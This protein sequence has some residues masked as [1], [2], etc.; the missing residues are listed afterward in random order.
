MSAAPNFDLL[1]QLHT[2]ARSRVLRA[3]GSDGAALI[4]KQPNQEFPSFQDNAR[5]RREFEIARRCAH[6]GV[7]V[8]LSLTQTN[9]HWT[10]V[11]ADIGGIALDKVLRRRALGTSEFFA[12]A[13]QLCD[14]VDAVHAQGVIHKDINPSNLVWNAD[15]G[16]LQLIDFGIASELSQE[17]QGIV[18][19][20]ALEGTLA[21][22]APE[23]TGRMNRL[24][25]YRADLYAI[26]ATL[27]TLLAGQPP[28][29][30][31]DAMELIHCHIARAPGWELPALQVLPHGLLAILQRLLEKDAG[32][33]YQSLRAL[34]ADLEACRDARAPQPARLADR[35]ARFV[36][37]HGLY[38]RDAELAM[39]MAA[40]ER[41]AAGGTE[42]LLVAGYSGIGK[43]ALV[44]EV[45][46]PIVAR[47]GAFLAGKFDQFRR[48]VPYA[49]LLEALRT[50]VHQLL[51]EPEAQLAARRSQLQAALG[52]DLAVMVEL[53]PELALVAGA[54]APP[55]AL[56]PE[57]AQ[58]R[59]ARV[60]P[61]FIDVFKCA[62]QPLVVFLD[63]LQWADGPTLRMLELLARRQNGG[64]LLLIGAYRDNETAPSHPLNALR[65]RLECDGEQVNVIALAPLSAP[66]VATLLGDALRVEVAAC[67][68]L[69][70][71]C[72]RKT[73]GNPFFLNQFLQAIAEQGQ[74]RYDAAADC[75]QWD[76]AAI[77][78]RHTTDNVGDLLAAQIRRLPAP[79]RSLLQLGASIGSRFDLATLA[80]VAQMTPQAAQAAMWPALE[81]GLV[82]PLDGS[83]KYLAHQADDHAGDAVDDAHQG[84]AYRFLHD[85]V[86]QAAYLLAT[87]DERATRHLGI[88]RMLLTHATPAQR[89]V[90]LFAI[91]E[92]INAGR[93]LIVDADERLELARLNHLAAVKARRS[94]AFGAALAHHDIGLSLLPERWQPAG[95][96]HGLWFELALGAAEAAYLC[97]DFAQAEALYPRVR[98]GCVDRLEHVRCI[99]VQAHQYQLQGRLLDAIAVQREGLALL[100]YVVPASGDQLDAEG[101]RQLAALL[102]SPTLASSAGIDALA[103]APDMSDTVAVAAMQ[104][105][106]GLWMAG[107]YAGQQT[108]CM[109][110]IMSMTR[111]SIERGNSDFTAVGYTGFA[112][113]EVVKGVDPAAAYRFGAMAMRL[114]RS[115]ANLQ[116][117]TLSSLMFGAATSHWTRPLRDSDALYDEALGWALE[118]GDFVQVGVV[119]A[120]RATDR[121]I[122]GAYLPDL[123]DGVRRDLA[124][125]RANGQHAMADCCVAAA[126]QP[127]K[128]LMGA[129]VGDGGHPD[130]AFSESDFLTRYGAS[131]LY[132]AYYLQGKIRNAM[133]FDSVDAEQLAERLELVTRMMRGQAKVF[134]ATFYAAL[135]WLR[136]LRGE[137][138]DSERAAIEARLAPLVAQLAGWAEYGPDNVGPRYALVLAE[139]ARNAGDV[140]S[141]VR[142]YRQ[143]ADS[144]GAAGF[145]NIQALAH[146]LCAQ[147]WVEQGQPKVAAVF[148]RDAIGRYH[149]WGAQ[150]KVAALQ[151]SPLARLSRVAAPGVAVELARGPATLAG[152][153]TVHAGATVHGPATLARAAGNEAL[154]LASLLK[155]AQALGN[156]VGL[157]AV[158]GRLIAIVR[159]NSGAQVARLLLREG[160]G[161]Q[162]VWRLEA[163]VDGDQVKVLVGRE[164]DLHGAADPALPLSVLRYV[165]RSGAAVIEERIADAPL[166][167]ADPH[168]RAHGARSVM[169][170][171]I[172][173]GGRLDGLLYLENRLVEG[174]FTEE[175]VEFLRLL[176]AQ[177]MTSIA[178]ARMHDRLEAR[179]AERTAQLE[180]A[181]RKLAT[182][183]VTDSLTGL[184][185]R[186]HFDDVLRR[187]WA[188]GQRAE[189]DIG[190]IML[191]IDQFKKYNDHYGHQAGDVCLARVAAALQRALRRPGDL[192]ARY[193]GEEFCVVLTDTSGADAALVGEHLRAAIEALALEHAAVPSCMVSISVGV[194]VAR[195][196]STAAAD[197]LLRVADDALYRAKAGGRNRVVL[198]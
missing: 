114:A 32:R 48:D 146:E 104:M 172:R 167:A 121:V 112:M 13:V 100:G 81:A 152:S 143:A 30:A 26:G 189:I 128:E 83:Y 175:R 23:Q 124:L 95:E 47:R 161:E 45:H 22:M 130:D 79:A 51:G 25:D 103:V 184:A 88:G 154:D 192:V 106:Q 31:A 177:A 57:L 129:G 74:L 173:Q 166:F 24:L 62:G 17:A 108:L 178:H 28:F 198:G 73:G 105:M 54:Q 169:C 188:R 78:A 67:A 33:R 44:N 144:A 170:L 93:S 195:P 18:H 122:L 86:Q 71:L 61:A 80:V 134:D 193:G 187:E 158:L 164:I 38:G 63:D 42:L 98:A 196:T 65:A 160:E 46:K 127:V 179:V 85:R 171:P 186:R 91:V 40:F 132:Q 147:F 141:A 140:A 66:Q 168:V 87:L 64:N 197:G 101:E 5:F 27:Y 34:K 126:V 156:E 4:I 94:A 116:T 39:L 142:A 8:P 52:A 155:A 55:A 90:R 118:I 20:H 21:Y 135:I 68:Q 113:I 180:D 163:D 49:S 99:A 150:A 70:A 15:T 41:A 36:M 133:L 115:R 76:L 53:L 1:D 60:L 176:G 10:M 190:V 77:E 182:L 139:A 19:P 92:Q 162:A 59:L 131:Q 109:L 84:V 149:Q 50:L 194:A 3:R 69:A 6:A 35:S 136:A 183:S 37:P 120:V 43:S 174:C 58:A 72:H 153:A 159:E 165:L 102:A 151:A 157:G 137:R 148:L 107:Y 145:V 123:L 14:A 97:G 111:L 12:I 125:M 11:L 119:V 7:V 75:W 9:G 82:Q 16:V 89:E 117:R 96:H 110:M 56:A 185:N 29:V 2:S 138:L 181:N 191:D